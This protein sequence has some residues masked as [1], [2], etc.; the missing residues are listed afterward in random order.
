MQ[1][2]VFFRFNGQR[3]ALI[4]LQRYPL[5]FDTHEKHASCLQRDSAG[6]YLTLSR[7][8]PGGKKLP[9]STKRKVSASCEVA[10]PCGLIRDHC[11]SA[12]IYAD[13]VGKRTRCQAGCVTNPPTMRCLGSRNAS[14]GL[15]RP[16][17]GRAVRHILPRLTL[18]TSTLWCT[19]H[20][21]PRRF[22]TFF[23]VSTN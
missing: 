3:T 22:L 17:K 12:T 18:L 13:Q 6:K 5:G 9:R 16:R 20:F 21:L 15:L 19:F 2:P 8:V 14:W 23:I 1:S 10:R 7:S 4:D 11:I